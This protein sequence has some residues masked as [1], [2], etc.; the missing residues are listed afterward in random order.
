MSTE[1]TAVAGVSPA[2]QAPQAQSPQQT[3]VAINALSQSNSGGDS[4]IC[5]WQNCGERTTTPE[6]LYV[7]TYMSFSTRAKP[8]RLPS[9]VFLRPPIHPQPSS[10]P[11][12]MSLCGLDARNGVLGDVF[13]RSS[14]CSLR[15]LQIFSPRKMHVSCIN[16]RLG[17]R[18]RA[19]CRPQ[20]HKQPELDLPMGQLPHHHRQARP[21]H[22]AHPRPR[23]AQAS[24]V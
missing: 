4:L 10:P 19:P 2:G 3:Q 22:L 18:L 5:Q 24:Q 23:P 11:R 12:R 13:G 15:A 7:S 8:A 1:N 21:H 14:S 16:K 9:A 6:A 20:K 17:S